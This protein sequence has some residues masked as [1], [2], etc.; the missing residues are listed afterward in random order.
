MTLH[1]LS[2]KAEF[3]VGMDSL[4]ARRGQGKQV[5]PGDALRILGYRVMNMTGA[6]TIARQSRVAGSGTTY[7]SSRLI[8]SL[9][10]EDEPV[11]RRGR[12]RKAPQEVAPETEAAV[13][14]E[15]TL[16]PAS[17]TRIPC[18]PTRISTTSGAESSGIYPKRRRLP[19]HVFSP[20]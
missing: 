1:L 6:V 16:D 7:K 17:E 13:E 2:G 5:R 20:N 14:T 19:K 18:T 9:G 8:K 15:V 3:P 11:R 10:N 12:P 4:S